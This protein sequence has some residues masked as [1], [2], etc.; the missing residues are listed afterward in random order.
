MS[1]ACKYCDMRKAVY[2]ITW[3]RYSKYTLY[4]CTKHNRIVSNAE[5]CEHFKP[6]KNTVD[7]S[8]QR[9]DNAIKD[10]E[11]MIGYLKDVE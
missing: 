4:Y 10:I 1:K 6:R 5:T 8:V 7:L 2:R 3:Y 9:F 11:F